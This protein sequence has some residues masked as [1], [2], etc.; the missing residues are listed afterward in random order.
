[1]MA[2]AVLG[3]LSMMSQRYI[4]L[5]E[6][7]KEDW[8]LFLNEGMIDQTKNPMIDFRYQDNHKLLSCCPAYHSGID[9]MDALEFV[10]TRAFDQG[11][12]A[13]AYALHLA[14]SDIDSFYGSIK[15]LIAKIGGDDCQKPL[16]RDVLASRFNRCLLSQ[17]GLEIEVECSDAL[18][19]RVVEVY[20]RRI[21]IDIEADH[22]SS[23]FEG[24][25]DL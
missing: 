12:S 22:D 10:C 5:N 9:D 17:I 20:P 13:V 21:C 23:R 3:Y 16:Y 11:F 1:M 2:P 14:R 6:D 25:S 4:D 18:Y 24:S 8:P 15:D 19:I 7:R